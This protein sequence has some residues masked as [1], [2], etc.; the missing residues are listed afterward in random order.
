MAVSA[1]QRMIHLHPIPNRTRKHRP[2]TGMTP[3]HLFKNLK[4]N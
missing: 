3:V 4:T 1:V 2:H